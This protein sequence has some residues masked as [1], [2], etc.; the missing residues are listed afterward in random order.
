MIR[1]NSVYL[2]TISFIVVLCSYPNLSAAEAGKGWRVYRGAWFEI[3]YPPGFTVKP[4]QKS[5][6]SVQGYDSAFFLSP[7]QEVA[8]YVFSP[9]WKGTPDIAVGPDKEVIISQNVIKNKNGTITQV[10]VKA[11]NGNYM[12]SWVDTEDNVSNS[13]NIFGIKYKDAVSYNKYKLDYLIFKK[14]LKQFGD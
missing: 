13:R 12:W 7:D 3:K 2:L 10:T 1:R 5:S 11:K 6:T 14:S 4:A 8:F 9:Q